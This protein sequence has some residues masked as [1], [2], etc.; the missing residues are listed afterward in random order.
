VPPL[1]PNR[2]GK[3]GGHRSYG[4]ALMAT[5]SLLAI[6]TVPLWAGLMGR[7]FDRDLGASSA[8][9]ARVAVIM[10]LLPLAAGVAVRAWIPAAADRLRRSSPWWPRCSC[11]SPSWHLLA[12]PDPD[13]SVVLALSTACRHPAIALSIASANFPGEHFAGTIILY[14]IVNTIAGL[15]YL[16]WVR[17][18]TVAGPL[19]AV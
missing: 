18:R 17:R 6:V 16:A 12:G 13:H 9:I 5:L 19:A 15:L 11:R 14:L 8:A 1:L 4:L 2:E 3:A 7:V 10:A